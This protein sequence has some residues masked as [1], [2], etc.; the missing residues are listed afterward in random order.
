MLI[1]VGRSKYRLTIQGVNWLISVLQE[2]RTYCALDEKVITDISISAAVADS[3]LTK[4]EKWALIMNNGLLFA[5]PPTG[6]AVA[7]GD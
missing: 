5:T 6:R 2:L 4:G 1:S 3:D 7:R